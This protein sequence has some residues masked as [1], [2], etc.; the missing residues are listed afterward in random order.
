MTL[1]FVTKVIVLNLLGSKSNLDIFSESLIMI[2][3]IVPEIFQYLIF[4]G[5]HYPP[6][7]TAEGA[8]YLNFDETTN[9]DKFSEILTEM[10]CIWEF[11]QVTIFHLE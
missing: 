8:K 6:G 10:C 4:P 2:G 3:W 11:F 5:E 1:T 7:K 9:F